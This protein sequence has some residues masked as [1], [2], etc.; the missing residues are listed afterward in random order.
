MAPRFGHNRRGADTMSDNRT[1]VSYSRADSEFALKLASDLRAGGADVWLDQLDIAAGSRWDDAV[2]DAL[3][4]CSRVLV[5][6]SPKAVASQNVLDEVSFAIGEH[7]TVVPVLVETCAIPLRLHR[8][9]HVDFT[10]GYDAGLTRLLATLGVERAAPPPP[11]SPPPRPPIEREPAPA[12][13]GSPMHAAGV[14]DGSR[15]VLILGGVAAAVLVL[16]V[17][18]IWLATRPRIGAAPPTDTSTEVVPA[19]TPAPA[20]AQGRPQAATQT[21]RMAP[22]GTSLEA[23]AQVLGPGVLE[24]ELES[25]Q[26]LTRELSTR[27]ELTKAELERVADAQLKACSGEA[28]SSPCNTSAQDAV[29]S[30][31]N[32]V[33]TRKIGP[34]PASASEI[35]AL[36]YQTE[37][38]GCEQTY[39]TT[40]LDRF[41][42]SAKAAIRNIKPG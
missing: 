31:L 28:P 32:A 42:D 36:R 33:C 21:R 4:R 29:S 7:K 11:S 18:V 2:E 25:L 5:V 22:A 3:R 41:N 6:L 13:P 19:N 38:T 26:R 15:R 34:A 16:G 10:R 24:S 14:G 39:S 30:L 23:L 9:Q 8:L 37:V 17:A 12:E 27:T 40:L 35:A 1:F 20:P